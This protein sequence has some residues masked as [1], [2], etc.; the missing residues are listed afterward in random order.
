MWD[1]GIPTEVVGTGVKER[2]LWYELQPLEVIQGFQGFLIFHLSWL[3]IIGREN[4]LSGKLESNLSA[5]IYILVSVTHNYVF[6]PV[7]GKKID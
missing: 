4:V 7:A 1:Q 3:T 5:E 2:Q 6:L